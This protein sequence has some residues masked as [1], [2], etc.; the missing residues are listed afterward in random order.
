MR[1]SILKTIL[2]LAIVYLL[3]SCNKSNVEPSTPT[4]WPN[5]E[6]NGD[7]PTVLLPDEEY[8]ELGAIVTENGTPIEYTTDGEVG[9]LPGVYTVTYSAM[10]KDGIE[11]SVDRTIAILPGSVTN[12]VDLAGKY[13]TTPFAAG[14]PNYRYATVTKLAPGTY[15]TTNCWGSGSR[16]VIPAYFFCLDGT[17]LIV[18]EQTTNQRILSV[19]DDNTIDENGVIVWTISRPDFAPSGLTLTK[20]WKKID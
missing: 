15:Y 19:G 9:D 1:Y 14:D 13:E 11:V 6:L 8:V 4:Y 2:P 18:P 20:T 7:N 16:A 12:D 17:N 3:T 5:I 10:N